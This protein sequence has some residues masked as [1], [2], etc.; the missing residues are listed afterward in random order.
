MIA[1]YMSNKNYFDIFYYFSGNKFLVNNNY[2][3]HNLIEYRL[4]E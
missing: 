4:K 2:P 3:P 1:M